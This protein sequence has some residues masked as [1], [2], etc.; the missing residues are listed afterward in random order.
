M[1]KNPNKKGKGAKKDESMTGAMKFFLAGC[2][3]ELYL[4]LIRR[5]YINGGSEELNIAW[6]DRYLW[7]LMGVGAGIAVIGVIL[8]LAGKGNARRSAT[9]WYLAAAGAFVGGCAGL[10]RWNM[11]VLT[12]LT[13]L[14]PAVMLLGILWVL[15]DRQY[16]L[17]LTILGVTLLFLWVYRQIGASVTLGMYVKGGAVV[18]LVLLAGLAVGVKGGKL[19]KLIP[20][21]AEP[22]PVY[23]ACGLCLAGIAASLANA[24]VAYYTLWILA[25]VVFALAVY[26]T[27]KQL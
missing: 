17:A 13:I 22:F 5:F 4:L 16:A 24:V 26:Y 14:V 27:V 3:G 20:K 2:V 10:V 19:G 12:Y 23:L 15:Y 18:L 7:I 25:I 9:G 11:Y 1:A 8:G 21:G 6:F